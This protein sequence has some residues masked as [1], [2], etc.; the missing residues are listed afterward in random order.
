MLQSVDLVVAVSPFLAN[1]AKF[2]GAKK[3]ETVVLGPSENIFYRNKNQPK[4]NIIVLPTRVN[5]EKGLKY[6][7]PIFNRLKDKKIQIIG[8]GDLPYS[9]LSEIFT[10]HLGRISSTE[11]ANLLRRSKLLLD[12]STIEGLGLSALEAIMCDCSCMIAER[13]GTNQILEKENIPFY[14]INNPI[15]TDLLY[16]KT[17]DAFNSYEKNKEFFKDDYSWSWEKN[18]NRLIQI[19]KEK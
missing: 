18:I 15:Y 9:S 2:L 11:V 7:V 14:W 17:L 5:M 4:E 10:E 16:E 12:M 13:G 8:Y 1:Q 19:V 3:V 6:L